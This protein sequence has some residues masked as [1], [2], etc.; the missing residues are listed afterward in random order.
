MEEERAFE[1]CSIIHGRS[2]PSQIAAAIDFS[3]GPIIEVEHVPV[4][5][6]SLRN[7]IPG[8]A[9]ACTSSWRLVQNPCV[10]LSSGIMLNFWF[11]FNSTYARSFF[12]RDV[13]AVYPQGILVRNISL[14]HT[15]PQKFHAMSKTTNGGP[16]CFCKNWL[17]IWL[18]VN[19]CH[20]FYVPRNIGF[21]SSSQLTH[22]FSEGWPGP[23]NQL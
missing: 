18:V 22:I 21:M 2:K 8:V 3:Q 19:G 17:F 1:H 16:F 11:R 13:H 12:L 4:M 23:T 5:I 10:S 15:T 14:K 6:S 20:Q 9:A 7:T